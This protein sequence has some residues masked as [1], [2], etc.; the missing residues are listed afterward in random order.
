MLVR[1]ALE[2]VVLL[3]CLLLT[4]LA[5]LLA[6]DRAEVDF[7]ATVLGTAIHVGVAGNDRS[8]ALRGNASRDAPRH[9]TSLDFCAISGTRSV[10]AGIPTQSVRTIKK[11]RRALTARRPF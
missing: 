4:R 10:R 11:G 5:V 6:R 7:D 1:I 9:R 8:H 3:W 2:L